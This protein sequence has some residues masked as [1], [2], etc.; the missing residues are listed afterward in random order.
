MNRALVIFYFV[1]LAIHAAILFWLKPPAPKPPKMLN[2]TYV[3]VA[4]TEP[5]PPQPVPLKPVV[6]PPP[7]QPKIEPP[8]KLEE[9]P[10]PAPTP[11]PEMTIPEPKPIPPPK[12]PPAPKPVVVPP[13]QPKPVEEYVAVSEPQ[14][15]QRVEPIYPEQAKRWH[16]QG[17]VVL[18]LYINESG[19]LDKIEI[20][21][22]SGFPLLDNAAIR[23]MKM[24]HFNPALS[25][26]VPIRSHAEVTV[27]FRLE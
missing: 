9:K 25:G 14:Y 16:Q 15:A 2:E 26:S 7:P 3:D 4:L 20:A 22:S 18:S 19:A 17:I 8:P 13:P 23:A 5:P 27:T 10:Q 1:A 12:P 6:V 11:K 21:K 24:S